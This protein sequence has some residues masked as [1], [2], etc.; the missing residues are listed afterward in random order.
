L[1]ASQNQFK[2]DGE[3]IAGIFIDQL[4]EDLDRIWLKENKPMVM[5]ENNKIDFENAKTCYLCKKTF[6]SND[7]KCR[8]CRDHD[9]KIG[10][11]RGAAHTV[12]WQG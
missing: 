10:K 5:T 9:H 3:D 1:N 11:Y 12:P 7:K 4:E 8:K 2:E 6:T